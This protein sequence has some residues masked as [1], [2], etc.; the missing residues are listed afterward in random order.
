MGWDWRWG[1]W[2][3][4]TESNKDKYGLWDIKEEQVRARQRKHE[5]GREEERGVDMLQIY[6]CLSSS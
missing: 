4:K 1:D 3:R 6:Y 2:E 5:N